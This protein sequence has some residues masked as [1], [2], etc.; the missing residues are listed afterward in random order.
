M[1]KRGIQI[2]TGAEIRRH[3]QERSK[4]LF[5]EVHGLDSDENLTRDDTGRY[6]CAT[7]NTRHSTEMSYVRH[8]EGRKHN[9]RINKENTAGIG[10]PVHEIRCL[11]Q[12]GRKGY[13]IVIRYELAE[14]LPQ[15]RFVSSLEQGVEEY[16]DR[17]RYIVFVC[18]PYDNIGFRFENKQT[19]A[20]LMHQEL[21]EEQGVYAFRF[22]FDDTTEMCL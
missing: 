17:Y 11:V 10:V 21:D 4:K 8:R 2:H 3:R 5:F 14:E 19:D 9:A 7:C 15:Y 12:G 20:T 1:S 13:S 18:K 16:D 22:F 6:V